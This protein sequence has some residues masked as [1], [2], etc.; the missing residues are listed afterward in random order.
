MKKADTRKFDPNGAGNSVGDIFG[1][2]FT[3]KE[4][5]VVLVPVP[6]EM[7]TSY[8]RGT[9]NGPKAI[10]DASPQLDLFDAEFAEYGLSRP[11][12][13]GIHMEKESEKIRKLN[14][15]GC[16]LSKPVIA[17]GGR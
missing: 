10:L 17:K 6:F 8:G 14:K 9:A 11:W 12:E 5:N 4:S 15:T 3:A 2:P 16:E 13:F 7:T 1:L